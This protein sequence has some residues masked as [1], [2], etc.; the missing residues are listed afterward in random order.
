MRLLIY[1]HELAMGGSQINAIELAA[2]V[3]DFGHEVVV[4]ATPG[5]LLDRVAE[6]GLE[7]LEAPARRHSVDAETVRRLIGAVDQRGINLIHSYEWAP[8]LDAFFGPALL[9]GTPLVMT[10]LS[11]DVPGFLPRN[12][13][14]IVGTKGLA[15]EQSTVRP[16][17]HLMEPPVDTDFNASRGMLP[18]RRQLGIE[19][20][21][22]VIAVVGRLTT[23]LGK[24]QG[25]LAAISVVDRI[26]E[27][28]P[29]MLLVAGD[30]PGL[31]EVRSSA[32]A[33]NLRHG[34]VVIRVEG[35][36]PDPR[37]IYDAADVV[38]GMGSSALRGMSFSKP[39]VVQGADGFW[40]LCTP[41]NTARFLQDGFYGRG[42]QEDL[43]STLSRLLTDDDL[44]IAL[45]AYG[46]TL[47]EENFSLGVAARRLLA[48]YEHGERRSRS[49]QA[50][51]IGDYL[52]TSVEVAKFRASM[53]RQALARQKQQRGP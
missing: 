22:R 38:L 36:V 48:V 2:A 51:R 41:G 1:P 26:A 24:V 35:L 7:F 37:M 6:L 9:R 53:R 8:S 39:V 13:P 3:R 29:A 27:D 44:R 28:R 47:V 31:R 32:S 16:L 20:H 33:V 40:S 52:R 43:E 34:R 30:G 25:V 17:V 42:I 19:D 18:A 49:M 11:M 50:E 23:D 10:V 14:L 45:G 15:D 12:V 21:E 46:R 5:V 4:F